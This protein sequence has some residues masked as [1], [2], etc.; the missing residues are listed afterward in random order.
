MSVLARL[1][2]VWRTLTSRIQTARP[3]CARCLDLETQVRYWREREERTADRLLEVRGI[4]PTA[5]APGPRPISPERLFATALSVQTID[6]TRKPSQPGHGAMS[7][8]AA[9]G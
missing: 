6:S 2:L 4:A 8:D 3:A 7:G 5:K 1:S 9:A